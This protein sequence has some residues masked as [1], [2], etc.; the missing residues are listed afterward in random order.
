MLKQTFAAS[1]A[2]LGLNA[3]ASAQTAPDGPCTLPSIVDTAPLEQVSGTDLMTVAVAINGTAE[4]F[5]LDIG[6]GQTEIAQ[7]AVAQAGLPANPKRSEMVG[8]ERGPMTQGLPVG[9]YN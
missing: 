1:I 2:L 3:A 7:K 9:A 5:L 4:H 8:G 6:T